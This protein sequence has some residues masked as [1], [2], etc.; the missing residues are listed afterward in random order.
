METLHQ[1]MEFLQTPDGLT[2]QIC[3]ICHK[4]QASVTDLVHGYLILCIYPRERESFI[5]EKVHTDQGQ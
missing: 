2:D 3:N 5:K 1:M 4:I